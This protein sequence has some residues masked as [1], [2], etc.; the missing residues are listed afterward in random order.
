MSF[1][2]RKRKAELLE[3]NQK[4]MILSQYKAEIN[5]AMVDSKNGRIIKAKDL[6]AKIQKWD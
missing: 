5:Q 2:T 1:E 6:K 3:E 4:P